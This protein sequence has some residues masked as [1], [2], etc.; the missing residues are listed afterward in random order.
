M[1]SLESICHE[2]KLL[3]A[4]GRWPDGPLG[5]GG[6]F[7]GRAP[8]SFVTAHRASMYELSASSSIDCGTS[9]IKALVTQRSKGWSALPAAWS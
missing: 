8:P 7:L 3:L 9:Q 5:S 6:V 4:G 1:F 2:R